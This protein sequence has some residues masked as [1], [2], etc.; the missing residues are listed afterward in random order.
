MH[1]YWLVCPSSPKTYRWP[2]IT[3]GIELHRSSPPLASGDRDGDQPDDNGHQRLNKSTSPTV[4]G[5]VII[6]PIKCVTVRWRFL[7]H[8]NCDQV[9]LYGRSTAAWFESNRKQS[10]LYQIEFNGPF[11]SIL[12]HSPSLVRSL[13]LSFFISLYICLHFNHRLPHDQCYDRG[14][15]IAYVIFYA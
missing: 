13:L 12:Y 14:K 15:C 8:F 9:G 1:H 3:A 5:V 7:V 2:S 6:A 4:N 10:N 11:N